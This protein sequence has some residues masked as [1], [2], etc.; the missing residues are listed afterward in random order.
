ME[1][2]EGVEWEG[3]GVGGGRERCGV[4]GETQSEEREGWSMRGGDGWS[5]YEGC[6]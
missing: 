3:V 4:G 6:G 1:E 5:E 2:G